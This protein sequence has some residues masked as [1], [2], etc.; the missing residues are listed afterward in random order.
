M[1]A[2]KRIV[3]ATVGLEEAVNEAFS[4]YDKGCF[5]TRGSRA[6]GEGW[7]GPGGAATRAAVYGGLTPI[8][9]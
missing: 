5:L 2:A 8:K 3:A 1:G 7:G 9:G 4:F 6:R